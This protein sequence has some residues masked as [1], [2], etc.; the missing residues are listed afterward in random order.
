V[1]QYSKVAALPCRYAEKISKCCFHAQLGACP[2]A[3]P[4]ALPVPPRLD[5]ARISR[6][7]R[8]CHIGPPT[9]AALQNCVSCQPQHALGGNKYQ[10]SINPEFKVQGRR[11]DF[12][13]F[14]RVVSLLSICAVSSSLCLCK[15]IAASKDSANPTRF[16]NESSDRAGHTARL[17]CLQSQGRGRTSRRGERRSPDSSLPAG[18]SSRCAARQALAQHRNARHT[19]SPYLTAPRWLARRPDQPSAMSQPRH[20]SEPSDSQ[21]P[22]SRGVRQRQRSVALIEYQ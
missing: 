4:L 21:A 12:P 1:P 17:S 14:Q 11:S 18:Q 10:V 20:R 5:T 3:G 15:D 22:A 9:S 7:L 6:Q 13:C 16:T 2:L 19:R 8:Y